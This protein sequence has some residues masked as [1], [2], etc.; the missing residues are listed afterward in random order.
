MQENCPVFGYYGTI[1]PVK[2]GDSLKKGVLDIQFFDYPSE[3]H[4]QDGGL[5]YEKNSGIFYSGDL[6][7]QFGNG[8]GIVQKCSWQEEIITITDRQIPNAEKP[9]KLKKELSEIS[10]SFVAVGHDF[11]LKCEMQ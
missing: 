1:L 5:C 4:L 7:T 2:G 9:E 8:E 11:C 3:V 6:M 10:P